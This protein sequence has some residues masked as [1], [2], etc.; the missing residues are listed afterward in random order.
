[1]VQWLVL[2]ASNARG[3]GLIPSWG[4]KIA[5]AAWCGKNKWNVDVA[6]D[7][8]KVVIIKKFICNLKPIQLMSLHF[9][10]CHI[11]LPGLFCLASCPQHH[12]FEMH[13]CCSKNLFLFYCWV[14]FHCS[15][16]IH[17][18]AGSHL[19]CFRFLRFW[20]SWHFFTARGLLSRSALP[21]C[22]P[23]VWTSFSPVQVRSFWFGVWLWVC[24]SAHLCSGLG[25][26]K[27][28]AGQGDDFQGQPRQWTRHQD[29]SGHVWTPPC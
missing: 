20:Y 6:L 15:K 22:H 19:G 8:N 7:E 4:T 11:K 14:A 27:G 10:E 1:M 13:L 2:C 25:E 3:V 5:H 24:Q 9:L 26:S 23:P 29:R 18:P 16:L 28:R 17:L 21:F 12:Y